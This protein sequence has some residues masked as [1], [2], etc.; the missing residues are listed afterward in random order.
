[1]KQECM[2]L[3]E[4]TQHHMLSVRCSYT[5]YQALYSGVSKNQVEHEL[6]I[7]GLSLIRSIFLVT[8]EVGIIH[9]MKLSGQADPDSPIPS[10]FSPQYTSDPDKLQ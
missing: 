7:A 2:I 4:M 6:V 1:M 5:M 9:C 8:A 3:D 10:S